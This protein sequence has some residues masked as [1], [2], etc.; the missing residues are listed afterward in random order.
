MLHEGQREILRRAQRFNTVACGRR[1]GKTTLGLTIAAFGAPQAPGGLLSGFDVGWFAPTYKLL[2]EAWRSARR[3]LGAFGIARVDSQQHR[4]EMH[5][6]S[7]MDFWTL[8]DPDA[9][10]GRKYGLVIIDEAAMSRQLAQVWEAAIRPTLTDYGGAGWF[11]STPKGQ[12]FFHTL[13]LRGGARP[14]WASHHAPTSANPY[15]D[16][17][18]IDEARRDLPERIY[19]QEYE[20][21]FLES[22]GG[23]FRR[24]TDAIDDALTARM[25]SAHDPQDGL[26]RYVIGVDWGRFNDFTVIVVVDASAGAVVA[27]DRFNKIEYTFQIERLVAMERRF[28][29]APIIAEENAMGAPVIEQARRRN[30]TVRAFTTTNASKA[31]VVEDLSI[32]FDEGTIRIP[33]YAPLVAELMAFDQERMPSGAIRYAAPSGLHDDCVIA[34]ALAWSGARAS[35]RGYASGRRAQA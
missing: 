18:E 29:G 14:G 28:A 8:D 2:D 9:G 25:E 7:A 17:G 34:L 27:I 20:A 4:I 11:L 6:R 16:R 10:R 21:A 26:H 24:V 12:N 15:I 31:A 19:A 33:K 32:A 35:G 5:A 3:A 22:G 13:Y 23:V 30:L 1:F